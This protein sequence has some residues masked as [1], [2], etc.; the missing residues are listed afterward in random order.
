[1]LVRQV[2]STKFFLFKKIFELKTPKL[3]SYIRNKN[4][5][6][7]KIP[8]GLMNTQVTYR[9]SVPTQKIVYYPI[10]SKTHSRDL[11]I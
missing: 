6:M 9:Q 10:A 2:S 5:K 1:M 4:L 3:L 11:G 7:L 8:N